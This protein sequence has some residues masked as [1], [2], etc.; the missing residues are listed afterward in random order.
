MTSPK[1]TDMY[2]QGPSDTEYRKITSDYVFTIEVDGKE[3]LK[4]EKE[5]LR[6]LTAEAMRDISHLLRAS[7]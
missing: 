6:L 7:H 3:V 4:V 5:G 2:A 1:Y